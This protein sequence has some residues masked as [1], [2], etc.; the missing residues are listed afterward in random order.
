MTGK[1]EVLVGLAGATILF[2]VIVG[3]GGWDTYHAISEAVFPFA[4]AFLV[5][6]QLVRTWRS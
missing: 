4:V 1:Q 5:I 6:D 2:V 3:L